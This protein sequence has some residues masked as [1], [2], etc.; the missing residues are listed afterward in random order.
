MTVPVL[1]RQFWLEFTRVLTSPLLTDN[2]IFSS[3]VFGYELCASSR[4]KGAFDH[5]CKLKVIPVLSLSMLLLN[6][7]CVTPTVAN[8]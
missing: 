8:H 3:I 1:C 6:M 7:E 4:W 2:C 5:R